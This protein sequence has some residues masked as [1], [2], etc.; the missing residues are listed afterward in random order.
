MVRGY[1]RQF[2]SKDVPCVANGVI[3]LKRRE[4]GTNLFIITNVSVV[5]CARQ[6][7]GTKLIFLTIIILLTEKNA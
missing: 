7:V 1:A 3:I 2:F 5:V 6:F 4:A